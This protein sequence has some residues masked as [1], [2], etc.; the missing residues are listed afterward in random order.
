MAR[1]FAPIREILIL[2]AVVSFTGIP[3]TVLMPVFAG[4]VLHGGPHT[5][6]ILMAATGVGAIVGVLWLATRTSVL[7]LG[8]TL[9]IAGALFG[10]GLIGF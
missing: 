7:G 8:R 3:Y 10:L 2:L 5:F 9:S 4:Q 1:A 6:G